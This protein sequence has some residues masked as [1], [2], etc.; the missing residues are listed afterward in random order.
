MLLH[1][2]GPQLPI[3]EIASFDEER[4]IKPLCRDTGLEPSQPKP[5]QFDS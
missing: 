5:Y 2:L 4:A 3:L 1:R